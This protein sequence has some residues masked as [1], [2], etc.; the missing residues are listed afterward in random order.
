MFTPL[1][2]TSSLFQ[3][4]SRS[5]TMVLSR[6]RYGLASSNYSVYMYANTP[7]CRITEERKEG[8]RWT[9]PQKAIN[10]QGNEASL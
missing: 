9:T 3:H 10:T 5:S 4:P 7:V 1:G 2:S 6:G 8:R